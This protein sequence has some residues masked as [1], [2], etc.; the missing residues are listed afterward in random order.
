MRV[1]VAAA[2]LALE[3]AVLVLAERRGRFALVAWSLAG[4]LAVVFAAALAA[5]LTDFRDA[6]GFIDCWPHCT[7]IQDATGLGL[8]LPPVLF[9][10]LAGTALVVRLT[11]GR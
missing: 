1:V 7:A 9:L 8:L 5:L 3:V 6:N 11:R 2:F 4:V 10:V